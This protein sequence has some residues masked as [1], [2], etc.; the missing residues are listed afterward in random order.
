[1]TTEQLNRL[2]NTAC[3]IIISL[4]DYADTELSEKI[5]AF[6]EEIKHSDNIDSE[7]EMS[8]SASYSA[9]DEAQDYYV[10]GKNKI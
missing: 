8:Y 9:D 5:E 3:E 4:E 2:L 10:F 1:M 7:I 6:F